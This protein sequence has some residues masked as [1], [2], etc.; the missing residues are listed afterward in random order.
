MS[1]EASPQPGSESPRKRKLFSSKY[2]PLEKR[3]VNILACILLWSIIAYFGM[4][5]ALGSVIVQGPSM[6]PTLHH[7]QNFLFHRWIYF[8]RDPRR[9]D[10]VVLHDP[11]DGVLTIKRVIALPGEKIQIKD[12]LVYVEEKLLPEPY[13]GKGVATEAIGLRG[14]LY[15]VNG[16][17]YFVLGDNRGSSQDSRYFGGVARKAILGKIRTPRVRP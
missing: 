11:T 1:S 9:G 17:H 8:F 3:K 14:G 5:L 2:I 13:L 15:Q 12:G 4:R 10:I 16:G 7:G 6:Q